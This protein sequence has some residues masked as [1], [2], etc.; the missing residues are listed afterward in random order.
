MG[1][2]T[3]SGLSAAQTW[4]TVAAGRSAVEVLEAEEFADLSVRIGAQVGDFDPSTVLTPQVARR[5]SRVQQWAIAAADE[6]M[7]QAGLLGAA[8]ENPHRLAILAASGSG[9][10]EA[11]RQAKIG[12]ASCRETMHAAVA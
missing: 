11:M 1:A 6:A 4:E 10:V 12:R 9:P 7:A 8:P 2:I 3:P 5:L